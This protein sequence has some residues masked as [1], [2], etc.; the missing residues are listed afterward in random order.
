MYQYQKWITGNSAVYFVG[1]E[2]S[3]ILLV[4]IK[5]Q[6]VITLQSK[7]LVKRREKDIQVDI[8]LPIVSVSSKKVKIHTDS[9]Y[10]SLNYFSSTYQTVVN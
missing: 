1:H 8:V 5:N 2:C 10:F 4:N 7:Y 6:I 3:L 9:F